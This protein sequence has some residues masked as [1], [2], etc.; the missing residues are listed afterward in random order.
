MSIFSAKP[1]SNTYVQAQLDMPLLLGMEFS[2]RYPDRGSDFDE[3]RIIHQQSNWSF[4]LDRVQKY[5]VGKKRAV[6]VTDPLQHIQ[7]TSRGFV[8]M[9]GYS[10]CEAYHRKPSFLQG[11]ATLQ[12][13]RE[14]IRSCL[15]TNSVFDGT[16][17]NYRKSGEMYACKVTIMPIFNQ[18]KELVNFIA[19]E[20]EVD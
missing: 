19:L 12:S 17:L 20:E 13:T 6:V 7:W 10:F 11:P 5:L 18:E 8:R 3:I 2:T 9:T 16:I 15:N 1:F 14:E 4:D